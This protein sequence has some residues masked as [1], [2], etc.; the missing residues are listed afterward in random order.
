LGIL[1]NRAIN[2]SL[3]VIYFN[4]IFS[5]KSRKDMDSIMENDYELYCVIF[6]KEKVS[7]ILGRRIFH[8]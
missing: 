5:K 3:L 8:A 2:N 7:D 6:R 1:I 4:I